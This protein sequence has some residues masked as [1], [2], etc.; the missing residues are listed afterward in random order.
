MEKALWE[1]LVPRYSNDKKKYTLKHHH[2]WDEQVRTIA[3]GITI[4][5]TAR[6]HWVN[7]QG[8]VFVEE[9]IPVRVYCDREQLD[10]I[11]DLTLAYYDSEAIFAYKV[12]DDV[13]IKHR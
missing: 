2:A 13:I 4:L 12:S 5:R 6:G 10:A 1:I 11:T 7:P 8:I 3:A 9:M